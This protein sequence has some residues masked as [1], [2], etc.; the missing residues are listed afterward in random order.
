MVR[1]RFFRGDK[2][3]NT[4]DTTNGS[5][6]QG[7]LPEVPVLTVDC[8]S[9][10][11][12]VCLE[13]DLLP[14]KCSS[15][16]TV[17]RPRKDTLF[18]Y[19]VFALRRFFTLTGRATR[20][21][22][23]TADIVTTILLFAFVVAGFVFIPFWVMEDELV[24]PYLYLMGAC[25]GIV[26]LFI[27]YQLCLLVRRLHD[28]G[29]TGWWVTW[30]IVSSLVCA[31]FYLGPIIINLMASIQYSNEYYGILRD[32]NF[33]HEENRLAFSYDFTG[34]C[35]WIDPDVYFNKLDTLVT[36]P[37]LGY[38]FGIKLA[39]YTVSTCSII[40]NTLL[41]CFCF[42]DSQRGTNRYGCS[43]KYPIA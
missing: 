30:G 43:Y 10:D 35:G 6:G 26:L 9:C 24:N 28:I 4:E 19:L 2:Q 14:W 34:I 29:R 41:L 39:Y 5:T 31:C 37:L 17:L 25:A 21:E 18:S 7:S 23:W 12:Q 8:P 33:V 20:K 36:Y 42:V 13:N 3:M 22:Y 1:Q 40:L 11:R 27:I 38:S 32:L 16:G 15:C